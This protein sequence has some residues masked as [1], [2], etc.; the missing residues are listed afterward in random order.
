MTAQTASRTTRFG[1]TPRTRTALHLGVALT[2]AMTA[3][4]GAAPAG[5]ACASLTALTI[6]DV[7]IESATEVAAGPFKPGSGAPV[8]L[9]AHCRVAAVATPVPDSRIGIE[10]WLPPASAWNGKLLGTGNGGFSSAMSYP[11]MADGLTR[12]YA[13]VATDTGHTGDSMDFGIG[14]PEK[15]VDWAYRAVHVMTGVAKLVVRNHHGRFPARAYFTGCST[16]GHQALSEAQRYPGDY[17]GIIAGAPAGNRLPLIYAFLSTWLATH[18][19]D[20]R[21]ILPSSKLPALAKA[22]MNACDARDGL[23]DGLI[24]DPRACRFDPAAL[25][26]KGPESDACLTGEQVQAVRTIYEGTRNP[27]TEVEIFP[28]WA[29]GSEPGWRGY[30]TEPKEPVRI[31]LFTGWAF[32][33][34]Q[35]N[36]RS[37]DFDRDVEYIDGRLA[38]VNATSTDLGAFRKRGGRLLMYTGLADA[39]VPPTDTYKYYDRVVAAGGG[40]E[41]TKRYFRFFPVPGMG[42]CAG[43]ASPNRFDMLSA[44]E[45]WVEQGRAPERI[46]ASQIEDGRVVRSRPLCVY[47]SQARHNGA[48]SVDEEAQFVCAAG[49]SRA[50]TANA[51]AR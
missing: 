15:I 46:V 5:T 2:L 6:P 13:I 48:G 29:Y 23:K 42:H 37:F 31:G 18:G 32:H 22:V 47:P 7:R 1:P 36:P 28:G 17:D 27:R 39:V 51:T 45:A 20:G 35:W 38:F 4:P 26:C 11:A 43:G 19:D 30:I 9:P 49:R 21:Q 40:L 33:D 34:P 41:A 50:A 10:I 3:A 8:E 16:G 14:H 24:A 25:A 44:L 12:G